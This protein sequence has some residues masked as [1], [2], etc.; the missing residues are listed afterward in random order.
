VFAMKLWSDYEGRTIAEAYPLK[1]LVRPEG[2]S[3][4]FLTTN[5]TGTPALVR[6]IE[7]HFDE[8]DILERWK[9]VSEIGQENLIKMR[10]FGQTELDGTPLVYAVMEPTE[11]SLAEL[12]QNRTL[13][14]EESRELGWSLL[15]ALESLHQRGLIHGQVDPE[16][17]LATGE[18]IKLRSD[19]VREVITYPDS[20]GPTLEELKAQDAQA[21]AVV[22]LQGLTGRTSLQGSATL[23]PSPFDGIIR[24][25]LS[26]R[27]GLAEMSAALGPKP[28]PAPAPEPVKPAAPATPA[29]A[30]APA[31]TATPA[32][33]TPVAAAAAAPAVVPIARPAAGAQPA[34]TSSAPQKPAQESLF[35]APPVTGSEVKPGSRPAPVSAAANSAT[36]AKAVAEA[37]GNSVPAAPVPTHAPDV[38][39]RIVKSVV[40][41][42][43][44]RN[45][46]YAAIAAGVLVLLILGWRLMRSE[47]ANANGTA[48]PVSTLAEPAKTPSDAS[49]STPAPSKPSAT[50][51][52]KTAAVR[53]APAAT[54]PA[55]TTVARN[56]TPAAPVI[57]GGAGAKTTWR[58]VA[59]TYN[60]QDQAQQKADSIK[61]QHPGLTP[62]VFSPTGHAPYLVTVGGPMGH[63]QAEAFRNKARGQ[64]LPRDIYAQNYSR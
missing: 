14:N 55:P 11:I 13:T 6:I 52:G 51:Y 4:F 21:L 16:N 19:C 24:N 8:S 2:R 46:M 23:L 47:P 57:T 34:T 44:N 58:V 37:L 59:Y 49:P 63:D 36:S 3:A 38:R 42:E 17:I 48:K 62:E 22:L 1:K 29:A 56:I 5:G 61:S 43:P 10:K 60:H 40:E 27:W 39:H 41:Q 7:A 64:G 18:A 28:K 9:T 45:K 26:G 30:T 15:G 33:T 20:D 31:T 12:L 54:A 32:A 50:R 53:P 35:A 25:G